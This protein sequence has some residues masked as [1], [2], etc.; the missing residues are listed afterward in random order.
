MPPIA[1]AARGAPGHTSSVRS[2]SPRAPL[3]QDGVSL[4]SWTALRNDLGVMTSPASSG[5][6]GGSPAEFEPL[7]Q[8]PIWYAACLHGQSAR[9]TSALKRSAPPDASALLA[10]P[11]QRC[12][13]LCAPVP[14]LYPM[15]PRLVLPPAAA[16]RRGPALAPKAS[17]RPP[18]PSW[19]SL[20]DTLDAAVV[21]YCCH[22][23]CRS[24]I[25]AW[26]DIKR[27]QACPLC[28]VPQARCRAFLTSCRRQCVASPAPAAH[29]PVHACMACDACA[30]TQHIKTQQTNTGA[31]RWL[32]L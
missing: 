21:L 19:P 14:P 5:S 10:T 20:A 30:C 13:S 16:V 31:H 12:H 26:C 1:A 18:S 15:R 27:P 29:I 2:T 22:R 32:P 24:C 23:F 8:C 6:D 25:A 3:R 7:L 9:A 11:L 28:K 17:E 4:E